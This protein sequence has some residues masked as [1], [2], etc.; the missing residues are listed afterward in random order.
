MDEWKE[1]L[2]NSTIH[3][4]VHISKTKRLRRLFWVLIIILGFS[5]AG[6]LIHQSFSTWSDSPV[7]TTIETLPISK[8]TIPNMI[9]CPPKNTFTN[10]NYDLINLGNQTIET[11]LLNFSTPGYHTNYCKVLFSSFEL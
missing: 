11:D 1:L 2:Q 3:G 9:V 4:L 7:K 5:G 6:I 8:I 10:L